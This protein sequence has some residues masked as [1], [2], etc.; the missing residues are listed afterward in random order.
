[1]VGLMS[2]LLGEIL[3]ESAKFIIML[4]LLVVAFILGGKWRKSSD[5]KKAEKLEKAKA[6]EN[7]PAIDNE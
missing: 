7:K 3:Y 5:A 1:M 2:M 4:I 6:D